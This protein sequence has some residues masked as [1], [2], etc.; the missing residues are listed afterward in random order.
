MPDIKPP[1]LAGSEAETLH[2]MLQYQRDSLV[3]KVADLDDP[4]ALNDELDPIDYDAISG[5]GIARL[6]ESELSSRLPHGLQ[7]LAHDIRGSGVLLIQ[8][9]HVPCRGSE[10]AVAEPVPYPRQVDAPVDQP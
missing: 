5:V 3:R 7:K 10:V 8:D 1:C 2:A 4:W 6:T 9:L